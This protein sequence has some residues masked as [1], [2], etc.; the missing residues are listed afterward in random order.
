MHSAVYLLDSSRVSEHANVVIQKPVNAGYG[1]KLTTYLRRATARPHSS[2]FPFLLANTLGEAYSRY[3]Q[4]GFR[5][6]RTAICCCACPIDGAS[7]YFLRK[8]CHR[9]GVSCSPPNCS[10]VYGHCRE[11]RRQLTSQAFRG[12]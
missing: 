9:Y 10:F 2:T 11:R 3:R 5:L 7:G 8:P 4:L 6:P 12:T 1:A